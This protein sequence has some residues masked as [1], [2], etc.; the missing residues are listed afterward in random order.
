MYPVFLLLAPLLPRWTSR[1]EKGE[2]LEIGPQCVLE[3][4]HFKIIEIAECT[5]D[6]M[7]DMV[8]TMETVV[9]DHLEA[10]RVIGNFQDDAGGLVGKR[11]TAHRSGGGV[12]LTMLVRRRLVP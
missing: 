9:I 11:P 7:M 12:Y 3:V 10:L 1:Q 8:T 4:L 2:S 5:T 6:Q